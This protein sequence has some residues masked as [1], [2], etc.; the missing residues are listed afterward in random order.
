[1]ARERPAARSLA[2]A[3]GGAQ[4]GSADAAVAGAPRD[5]HTAARVTPTHPQDVSP[6]EGADDDPVRAVKAGGLRREWACDEPARG[7]QSGSGPARGHG[8]RSGNSPSRDLPGA[9]DS[10]RTQA[11]GPSGGG[12]V[13][14]SEGG[15]HLP[16]TP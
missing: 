10:A 1:M 5:R 3:R 6:P 4:L 13:R 7:G 2:A 8:G 11:G 9:P 14:A 15:E 16:L 12:S